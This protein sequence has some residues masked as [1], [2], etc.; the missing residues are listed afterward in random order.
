M[1]ACYNN[2]VVAPHVSVQNNK[3]TTKWKHK[4]IKSSRN[5]QENL[6]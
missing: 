5:T 2:D 6:I 4:N 3:E 1:A